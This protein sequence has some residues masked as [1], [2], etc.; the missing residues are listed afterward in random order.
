MENIEI[1]TSKNYRQLAGRFQ[2]EMTRKVKQICP[3][4]DLRII[5]NALFDAMPLI[6]YCP[7]YPHLI[8]FADTQG[9]SNVFELINDY[10]KLDKFKKKG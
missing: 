4:T 7:D 8:M 2:N 1:I 3:V 9:A 10:S 5:E 6:K